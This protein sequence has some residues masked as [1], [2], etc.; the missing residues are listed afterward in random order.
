MPV[1]D[2]NIGVWMVLPGLAPIDPAPAI[3]R[4]RRQ[5]DPVAAPVLWRAETVSAI[6][7]LVFFGRLADEEGEASIEEV[8]QIEVQLAPLDD[9][10]CLRAFR[11]AGRLRQRR[12]YDAFY[13]ALAERTG[14]RFW[15]GD[16]RLFNAC[17]ALRLDWVEWVGAGSEPLG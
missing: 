17:Q 7:S 1:I 11:W 8:T 10:L 16:Q 14:A 12:A 15:T 6:R 2:A 9:D 5:G 4:A 13:V 3:E